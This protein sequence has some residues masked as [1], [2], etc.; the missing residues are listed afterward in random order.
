[1]GQRTCVLPSGGRQQAV[2][3]R[4]VASIGKASA[5][6]GWHLHDR[7]LDVC[8]FDDGPQVFDLINIW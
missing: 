5:G 1:M 4:E 7:D 6:E 2:S 3:M 8:D